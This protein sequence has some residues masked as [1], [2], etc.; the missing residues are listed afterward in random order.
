MSTRNVAEVEEDQCGSMTGRVAVAIASSS[1]RSSNNSS[2]SSGS[3]QALLHVGITVGSLGEAETGGSVSTCN[4]S[5]EK[6]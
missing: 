5:A 4:G 3:K 1:G 2:R 6:Q